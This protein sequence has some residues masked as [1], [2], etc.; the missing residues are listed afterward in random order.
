MPIYLLKGRYVNSI[1]NG[2]DIGS[3][4]PS[5]FVYQQRTTDHSVITLSSTTKY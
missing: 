1:R 2:S 3:P 5:Y 4:Y